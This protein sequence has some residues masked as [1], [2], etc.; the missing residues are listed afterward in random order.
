MNNFLRQLLD[1]FW[2]FY[3]NSLFLLYHKAIHNGFTLAERK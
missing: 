1:D 2:R 3:A